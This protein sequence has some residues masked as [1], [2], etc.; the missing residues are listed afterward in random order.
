MNKMD[1]LYHKDIGFPDAVQKSISG[2][3]D[4]GISFPL[5]YGSHAR[6]Q[7]FSDRYGKISLPKKLNVAEAE[8][9]EVQVINNKL[10]KIL[11]RTDHDNENDICLAVLMENGFVKTV[12]LNE[13]NDL[14]ATLDHSKYK[15]VS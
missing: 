3:Q 2:A 5:S 7:A 10:H 13:K 11:W 14:H 4:R 8:A 12:W 1:G 6:E 9:I 15:E